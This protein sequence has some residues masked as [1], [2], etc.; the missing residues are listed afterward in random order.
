MVNKVGTTEQP[1]KAKKK[2]KPANRKR[3]VDKNTKYTPDEIESISN[4]CAH[5]DLPWV[6]LSLKGVNALYGVEPSKEEK[7]ATQLKQLS[8]RNFIKALNTMSAEI[9][10]KTH[11]LNK[12]KVTIERIAAK[13]IVKHIDPVIKQVDETLTTINKI[14][15]ELHQIKQHLMGEEGSES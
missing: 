14:V 10:R 7:I 2:G 4:A 11:S 6:D 3:W 8:N 12:T 15:D 9:S 13:G 1:S 5:F